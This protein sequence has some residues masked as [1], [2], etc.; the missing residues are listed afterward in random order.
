LHYELSIIISFVRA[1]ASAGRVA[2]LNPYVAVTV[3]THELNETTN[4]NYLSQF[5]VSMLTAAD[6]V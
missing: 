2:E 6:L 4:L 3:L 1:S 5:Q